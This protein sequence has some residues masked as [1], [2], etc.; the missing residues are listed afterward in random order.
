MILP[1]KIDINKAKASERKI[2]IDNGVS[3]ASQIDSL[4]ATF[5]QE[6]A[7]HENWRKVSIEELN[8][9][10]E[11]LQQGIDAKK[12]ELA[13][14]AIERE[15]LISPLNEEWVKLNQE[16]E[17]ISKEKHELFLDKERFKG[18]YFEFEKLKIKLEKSIENSELN[19]KEAELINA[20]ANE[21]KELAKQE[22]A[23]A[24]S[25]RENYGKQMD[26]KLLKL[27]E[28][29]K[30]Y[31]VSLKMIGIR[32]KQVNDLESELITREN[33]LTRRINNLQKVEELKK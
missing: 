15:K 31:E 19:E 30:E 16:K 32:E 33:G 22:Y 8:R 28:K 18:E 4:R 20:E 13:V 12:R 3:I 1:S 27:E 26:I 21:L 23:I 25:E 2:E 6:K 29:R 24:I 7:I 10:L 14:L 9:Q 11:G 17:F 5:A